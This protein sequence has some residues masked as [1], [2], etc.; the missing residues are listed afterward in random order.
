MRET[1]LVSVARSFSVAGDRFSLREQVPRVESDSSQ[2]EWNHGDD[3]ASSVV[4]LV[5]KLT[6]QRA[7]D[8]SIDP[9]IDAN[10]ETN[11]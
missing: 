9:I 11:N 3:D 8:R 5:M 7:I 2:R 6:L 1:N 4:W 10:R